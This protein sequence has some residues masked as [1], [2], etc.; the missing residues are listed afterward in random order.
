MNAGNDFGKTDIRQVRN[1]YL[2]SAKTDDR[3]LCDDIDRG[4]SV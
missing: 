3:D 2:D 4:V 1:E